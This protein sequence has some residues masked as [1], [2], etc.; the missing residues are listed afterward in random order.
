MKGVVIHEST[1][2]AS[3]HWQTKTT[4]LWNLSNNTHNI[5]HMPKA[6][7]QLA[8]LIKWIL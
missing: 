8:S 3:A 5:R 4:T 6:L 7:K 1:G 2:K